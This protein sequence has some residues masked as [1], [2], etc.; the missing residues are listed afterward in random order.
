MAMV[1]N[2]DKI[3]LVILLLVCMTGIACSKPGNSAR[4]KVTLN[5]YAPTDC[6]YV[7]N[8][9]QDSLHLTSRNVSYVSNKRDTLMLRLDTVFDHQSQKMIIA[10]FDEVKKRSFKVDGLVKNDAYQFE[11]FLNEKLIASGHCCNAETHRIL[12]ICLTYIDER[13]I[14]CSDFFSMIEQIKE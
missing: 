12:K 9:T 4:D 10:A 8:I 5:V 7:F 2:K 11:L 13:V 3:I 6:F 1:K 14:A